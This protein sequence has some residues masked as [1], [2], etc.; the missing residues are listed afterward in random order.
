MVLVTGGAGFVGSHLVDRLVS[1]G[2]EVRVLDDLSSGDLAN[3]V[4]H[5]RSG[6]VGFVEGDVRDAGVVAKC[7]RGVD[8]VVHCAAVASVPFSFEHPVLTFEVNVDG[9]LNLL[10]ACAASGVE[11]F[12]F[13][14]S[15]A[16]YGE[17]VYLP[18]DEVH[19][20]NPVS[21]YARSKVAGERWCRVFGEKCGLETVVLRLFNVYG[22]RQR[23]NDYS[24]VMTRFIE[25]IKRHLPLIVY[26]DGS[27][28]RDFVYVSDAVEAVLRAL[29]CE[30]AAGEVFNVGCG[31]QVSIVDLAAAVLRLAQA[32]LDVVHEA[33]RAGDVKHS[34]ADISK[35]ERLLGFK[36]R[37]SLRDGLSALLAENAVSAGEVFVEAG[38]F[39]G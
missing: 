18:V 37:F 3:I 36:P 9:T 35:A 29:K 28:T 21:P 12:V 33:P 6:R 10:R 14:S 22:P 17:P 38:E 25:R 4:G 8:V 2:C 5:V 30:G 32:N 34:V 11:R 1:E 24:G 19:P 26:G 16:V 20:V 15:C 31:R 39:E 7:V 13:V 27:Q 23:F